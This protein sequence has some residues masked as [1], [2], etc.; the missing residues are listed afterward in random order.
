VAK[1]EQARVNLQRT[2]IRSPVNG[3]VTNL[4]AQLGDYANVGTNIISLVDADSFWVDGYFE[5]TNVAPIRLGDP[6]AIS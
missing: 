4:L 5:E 6:A 2:E 1:L 3:W